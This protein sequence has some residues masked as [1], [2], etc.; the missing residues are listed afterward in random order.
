MTTV[1]YK[2]I[3]V[4]G[5]RF[6]AAKIP[7]P[8]KAQAQALYNK[9]FPAIVEHLREPGVNVTVGWLHNEPSADYETIEIE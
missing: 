5:G 8:G 7:H 9:L 3:K 2:E 1:Y 4:I 6:I